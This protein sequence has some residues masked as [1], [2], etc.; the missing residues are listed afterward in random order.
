MDLGKFKKLVHYVCWRC[1]SDPTK[2]GAVKLNK[3]LWIADATRYYS[4]GQPL[5]GAR[6]VRR[7]HGPVPAPILPVLRELEEEGKLTVQDATFHGMVKKEYIVHE[8]ADTSFLSEEERK[9]VEDII[10]FVCEH[11]TAKSIS[12]AT[13]DQVWEVAADGETLPYNT[14]FV[15]PGKI[16]DADRQ[17]AHQQLAAQCR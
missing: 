3:I 9:L 6:Y 12:K 14:V 4:T 11:H 5:T 7:Q 2:L 16:T 13:H 10:A 17:W 1:S 8:P 15:R